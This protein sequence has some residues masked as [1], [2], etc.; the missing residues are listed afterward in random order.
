MSRITWTRDELTANFCTYRGPVYRCVEAQHEVATQTVVDTNDEQ[1]LVEFAIERRK[2]AVPPA[3]QGLHYL[4][5]TP[6]RYTRQRRGKVSRFKAAGEDHGVFYAGETEKA[7]L[8]ETAFYILLSLAETIGSKQPRWQGQKSVFSVNLATEKALDLTR[9]PFNQNRLLWSDPLA[10][11]PCQEIGT[12]AREAGGALI[13]YL[14][15]RDP[16]G[17]ANV[18]LFDPSAFLDTSPQHYPTWHLAADA[19]AVRAKQE[20]TGEYLE[21]PRHHFDGDERLAP[22]WRW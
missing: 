18:A 14:S 5:F 11:E 19:Q 7:A 13:R 15:A 8:A 1:R 2:P 20:F 17:T 21:F 9:P 16:D 10:Y 12:K 22:L 6:F 4:L 3:A